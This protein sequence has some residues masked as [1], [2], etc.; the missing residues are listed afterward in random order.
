MV[1]DLDALH[2]LDGCP[3]ELSPLPLHPPRSIETDARWTMAG[4]EVVESL[5]N[6]T[7]AVMEAMETKRE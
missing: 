4:I 1:G 5:G 7:M 2:D 3:A 6:R